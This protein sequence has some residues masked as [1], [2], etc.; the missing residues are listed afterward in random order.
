MERNKRPQP[1]PAGM[2]ASPR[3]QHAR[4]VQ[5]ATMQLES[6][7]ITTQCKTNHVAANAGCSEQMW[8]PFAAMTTESDRTYHRQLHTKDHHAAAMYHQRVSSDHARAK[9]MTGTGGRF[10]R[11][12][13]DLHRRRNPGMNE[14]KGRISSA[15]KGGVAGRVLMPIDAHP[16]L[17]SSTSEETALVA[18]GRT[19][20]GDGW[21]CVGLNT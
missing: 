16:L 18:P 13:D 6:V 17:S 12:R 1:R 7:P 21:G 4:A 11:S 3:G 5:A 19:R 15:C 10:A 2:R 8:P 20:F 14:T 9:F